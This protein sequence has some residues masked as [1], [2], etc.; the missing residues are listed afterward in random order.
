MRPRGWKRDALQDSIHV[1][2]Q[3]IY[4]P[5][6]C[7]TLPLLNEFPQSG[8]Y[9]GFCKGSVIYDKKTSEMVH[10]D[11]SKQLIFK[12]M[13]FDLSDDNV[14]RISGPGISE[15]LV[16]AAGLAY[17]VEDSPN[18]IQK[19]VVGQFHGNL[20]S[21]EYLTSDAFRGIY[22]ISEQGD[23]LEIPMGIP[24]DNETSTTETT[25]KIDDN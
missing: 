22:E 20:F 24:T 6:P 7:T 2:M 9:R 25:S 10:G 16:N 3:S 23:D 13:V 14:C 17:W 19:L 12:K 4:D 11:G 18:G 1:A 8:N 15:G 21:G 5:L